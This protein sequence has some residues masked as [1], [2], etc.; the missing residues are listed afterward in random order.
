[1]TPT[2]APP[3][4]VLLVED[5][6]D[7]AQFLWLA[8]NEARPNQATTVCSTGAQAIKKLNAANARFDLL[9]VDIGL[10][11]VS[12]LEVIALAHR[13]WPATPIMVVSVIASEASV[14]AAIRA[15]ARGY[16][17]KGDNIAAIKAAIADVMAGNYP[18]SPSLARILFRAVG[19]PGVQHAASADSSLSAREAETLR[20]IAHGS[21][22]LETANLMGV[23]L[24]TIQTNIRSIYR[25][26]D[27]SNQMLAV[28]KAREAG[29][30]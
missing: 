20:H 5:N 3:G 29:L 14:L 16:I 9:L 30:I 15:G 1:M 13:R 18:I 17:N 21:T 6:S 26:L 25:K 7:F 11:D 4:H 23:K 27:V 10:P 8:L 2:D 19:G 22:Y 12:G 28:T 24:S